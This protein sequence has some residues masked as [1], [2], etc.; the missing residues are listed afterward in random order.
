MLCSIFPFYTAVLE[1]Y[2]TG[3]MV[4]PIING[5]DDGSILVIVF[6][7]LSGYFGC[8]T[9]W[10]PMGSFMGFETTRGNWFGLWL[11]VV[12]QISVIGK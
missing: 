12:T 11:L 8:E 9:L 6:H 1:Q 5:I 10:L 3:E 7:C 4:L 2:Y